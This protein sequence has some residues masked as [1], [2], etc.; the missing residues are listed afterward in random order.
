[1]DMTTGADGEKE[2]RWLRWPVD[3]FFYRWECGCAAYCRNHQIFQA[4]RTRER[5]ERSSKNYFDTACADLRSKRGYRHE[6]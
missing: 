1:M 4:G 2:E 3:L 6:K 5:N